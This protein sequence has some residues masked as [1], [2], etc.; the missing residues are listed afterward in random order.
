MNNPCDPK[1][2]RRSPT[3]HGECPEYDEFFKRRQKELKE[4]LKQPLYFSEAT[5]RYSKNK[6]L[7]KTRR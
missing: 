2:P 1:C 5:I 6:A 3:C 4:K 7:G